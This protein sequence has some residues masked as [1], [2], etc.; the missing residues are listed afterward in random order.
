MLALNNK[1]IKELC[2][3]HMKETA[4]VQVKTRKANVAVASLLRQDLLALRFEDAV[5]KKGSSRLTRLILQP[6]GIAPIDSQVIQPNASTQQGISRKRANM[7]KQLRYGDV[8]RPSTTLESAEN[9]SPSSKR[10]KNTCV[11]ISSAQHNESTPQAEGQDVH[12]HPIE[13]E[14]KEMQG[15]GNSRELSRGPCSQDQ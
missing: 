4:K 8:S 7:D 9:F 3:Y 15:T 5:I 6:H 13:A 10:R 12:S 11:V 14:V 1:D 2:A